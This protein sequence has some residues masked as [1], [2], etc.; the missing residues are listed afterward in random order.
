MIYD[1]NMLIEIFDLLKKLLPNIPIIFDPVMIASTGTKLTRITQKS[2]KLLQTEVVSQCSLITPNIAEAEIISNMKIN[3]F[4]QMINAGQKISKLGAKNIL[5]KGSHLEEDIIHDVLIMPNLL[6][7][8]ESKRINHNHNHGSG[9][10][11][12]S[13]I[14]TLIAQ[15]IT[16]ELAIEK[17]REYVYH[18]I[19]NSIIIGNGNGTLNHCLTNI[20]AV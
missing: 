9:C 17:A 6:K 18:A 20:S 13:A 1:F 5:L 11:L 10:S 3:N 2:L 16:L 12:S 14:A 19:N 8:Y 15:N 4:D 7:I